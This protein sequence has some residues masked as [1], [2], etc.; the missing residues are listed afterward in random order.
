I[1]RNS[2]KSPKL[3]VFSMAFYVLKSIESDELIIRT[4]SETPLTIDV[5]RVGVGEVYGSPG[6]QACGVPEL[7]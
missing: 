7:P 3:D 5:I 1:Q 4:E 2:D 6:E